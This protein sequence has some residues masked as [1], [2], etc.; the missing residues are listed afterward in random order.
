MAA[1]EAEEATEGGAGAG[2]GGGGACGGRSG[3]GFPATDAAAPAKRPYV[4]IGELRSL[5][6]ER[7]APQTLPDAQDPSSILHDALTLLC[8]QGEFF[9]SG[10]IVFLDPGF[11]TEMLAPL[12]NHTL[13]A[14]AAQTRAEVVTHVQ[15]T[16]GAGAPPTASQQ[17]LKQLGALCKQG[18]LGES[19][20]P[21]LWR[22][23]ALEPRD[24]ASAM[25]ML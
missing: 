6:M 17:L 24:Y 9:V 2:Q 15:A 14:E 22:G 23:T 4:M 13:S 20:L 11:A 8:N 18:R 19:L 21:F 5:W 3:S 7:V 16:V 12:V 10:G 1:V 25:L